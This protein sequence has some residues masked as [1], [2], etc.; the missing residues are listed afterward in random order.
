LSRVLAL[1]PPH[2]DVRPADIKEGY[3]FSMVPGFPVQHFIRDYPFGVDETKKAAFPALT[4]V[5]LLGKDQGLL[6]LHAGTQFFRREP[7]GAVSN[8][9]MREW[10]SHFT[11]EYGWPLYAEYRHALLPHAGPLSNAERLRAAAGFT[12]P[13]VCFV[14]PA[15]SAPLPL[16]QSFLSLSPGGIQ[17]SA[18]RKRPEGGYELRIVETEGKKEEVAINLN[19]PVT[20]AAETDLLDNKLAEVKLE[21]G[22]L[23]TALEP[24]KIRTF[25]LD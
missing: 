10:E 8:L 23:V 1:L 16:T 2:S 20:K 6:V 19:L 18:F 5:D 15:G 17:L 13:L 4:F 9:V 22:K 7:S 14:G 3:W 24:W 11:K 25:R 12:R 21:K